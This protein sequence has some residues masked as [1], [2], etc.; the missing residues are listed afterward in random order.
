MKQG[1]E[2]P[3]VFN[4]TTPA[5][6]PAAVKPSLPVAPVAAVTP[7]APKPQDFVTQNPFASI[8]P[9]AKTALPGLSPAPP[10]SMLAEVQPVTQATIALADP[11]PEEIQTGLEGTPGIRPASLIEAVAIQ[12]GKIA[13]DPEPPD[14]R[15]K[16]WKEWKAR[17][18]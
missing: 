14:K 5:M 8:A 1:F 7:P 18:K 16:D 6:T 12:V 10:P 13:D 3:M 4:G 9:N 2:W 11:R 15:K 17:Q